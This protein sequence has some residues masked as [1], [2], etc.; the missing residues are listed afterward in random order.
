[1]LKGKSDKTHHAVLLEFDDA[2]QADAFCETSKHAGIITTTDEPAV[3]GGAS[4]FAQTTGVAPNTRQPGWAAP[5]NPWKRVVPQRA[6]AG[7]AESVCA[8]EPGRST[9][10]YAPKFC[11]LERDI[12]ASPSGRGYRERRP[13]FVG[14]PMGAH[15][16][17]ALHR[18]RDGVLHVAFFGGSTMRETV[19]AGEQLFAGRS[20][21]RQ[22]S[23]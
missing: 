4:I 13:Q 16:R 18:A 21:Q 17:E 10:S 7:L 11:L 15:L 12:A 1:M 22:E 23:I 9:I 3:R 5:A 20:V 19:S 6:F 2:E 8:S 14:L